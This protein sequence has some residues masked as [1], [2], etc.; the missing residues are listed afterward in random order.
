M[1]PLKAQVLHILA[2]TSVGG[3]IVLALWRR[4]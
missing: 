1:T 3:S 2:I 4:H